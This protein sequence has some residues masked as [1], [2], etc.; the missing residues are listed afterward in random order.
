MVHDD[1]SKTTG[2]TREDE[3][4]C[5]YRTKRDFN[6][7]PEPRGNFKHT[8]A[9]AAIFVVQKHAAHALHYDFRLEINGVL[10]SWAVPKGP[11]MNPR[12]KRL[13]V[14]T[15]DHP[16]EYATFEGSI[17]AG[18]YGAGTVMVWDRGTFDTIARDG[19]T[20]SSLGACYRRGRLEIFLHGTKLR[21]GYTLIRLATDTRDERWLLIKKRD[22]YASGDGEITIEKPNSALSGMSLEELEREQA[23]DGDKE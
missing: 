23:P 16:L 11:S 8:E 17:P 14:P 13:A 22:M 3:R 18:S 9:A 21:G 20:D 4:L 5:P 10:K 19:N 1:D 7:S 6:A 2:G 15:E 12:D